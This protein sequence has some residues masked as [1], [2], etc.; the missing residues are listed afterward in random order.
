MPAGDSSVTLGE[1]EID[2]DGHV[3]GYPGNDKSGA[4]LPLASVPITLGVWHHL[5]TELDFANRTYSFFV[6]GTFIGG[7]FRF[8]DEATTNLLS[9]GSMVVYAK[10]DTSTFERSNY[11]VHFDNFS[12]TAQ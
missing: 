6:D 7:P 11:V 12:I 5:A 2:A 8:P 4:E 10:P 9:R 3:Y 1:L